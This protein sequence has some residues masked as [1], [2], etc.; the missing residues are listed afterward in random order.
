MRIVFASLTP[1]F[2]IPYV[3]HPLALRKETAIQQAGQCTYH[4]SYK[5]ALKSVKLSVC[6]GDEFSVENFP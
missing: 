3:Y 1:A 4:H 2:S 6:F 5:N